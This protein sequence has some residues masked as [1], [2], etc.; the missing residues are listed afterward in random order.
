MIVFEYMYFVPMEGSTKSKLA[1][2]LGYVMKTSIMLHRLNLLLIGF[3]GHILVKQENGILSHAQFSEHAYLPIQDQ[4]MAIDSGPSVNI[5]ICIQSGPQSL[6]EYYLS[7]YCR[8]LLV[9]VSE[10]S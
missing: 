7:V 10:I 6:F 1:S 3:T 2:C 8:Q 9:R 4:K 5:F